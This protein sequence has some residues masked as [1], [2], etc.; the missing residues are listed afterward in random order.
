MDPRDKVSSPA[1]GATPPD[2]PPAWEPDRRAAATGRQVTWPD[3]LISQSNNRKRWEK[4]QP[5]STSAH[6]QT[7]C[8]QSAHHVRATDEEKR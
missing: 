5:A 8:V 6:Q 2:L 4:K 3:T 7:P 1:L